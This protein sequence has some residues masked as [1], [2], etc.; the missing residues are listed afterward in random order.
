M[1]GALVGP[2]GGAVRV[3]GGGDPPCPAP[4]KWSLSVSL[5]HS[6]KKD[7]SQPLPLSSPSPVFRLNVEHSAQT[8]AQ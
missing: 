2:A 4:N 3:G 5:N 6:L 1:D 8:A 7:L